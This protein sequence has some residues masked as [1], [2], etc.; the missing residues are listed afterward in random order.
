MNSLNKLLNIFKN[1]KLEI[2]IEDRIKLGFKTYGIINQAELLT[3]INPA[4]NELW[5]IIIPGYDYKIIK[6]HFKTNDIIGLCYVGDGNHKIFMKI[7]HKGF[8]ENR[9]I[10]DIN[11]YLINY[12]KINNLP[13]KWE[14]FD[15]I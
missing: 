4:D 2:Q 7:D 5:D 9:S 12:K 6:K 11:N 13:V 1:K 8:N 14:E 15:S 3:H 10:N